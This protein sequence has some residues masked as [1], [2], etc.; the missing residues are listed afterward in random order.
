[1]ETQE[2][3][4]EEHEENAEEE[5]KYNEEEEEDEESGAEILQG[6]LD[7][8][9]LKGQSVTFTAVFTGSPEPVVSWLKKV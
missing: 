2:E 8:T 7:A 1:M 9:V 3:T 6:P 4:Q 5:E